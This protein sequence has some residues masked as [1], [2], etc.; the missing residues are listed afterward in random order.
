MKINIRLYAVM[1]ANNIVTE[2]KQPDDIRMDT[3]R[4][5]AAFLA[6]GMYYK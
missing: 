3:Q 1:N 2:L 6:R 4:Y 5:N